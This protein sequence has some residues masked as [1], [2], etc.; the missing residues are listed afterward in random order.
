[1]HQGKHGEGIAERFMNHMP[2]MENILRAGQEEK[3]L[4]KGGFF[5]SGMDRLLEFAMLCGDESE[6]RCEIFASAQGMAAKACHA[7]HADY[8]EDHHVDKSDRNWQ[9]RD[10]LGVGHAQQ[11]PQVGLGKELLRRQL[12]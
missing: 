1:M 6:K 2:G 12:L 7:E 5:S 3:A 10:L 9:T 4:G 11:R 8:V